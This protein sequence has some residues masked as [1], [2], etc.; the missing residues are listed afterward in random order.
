MVT[1]IGMWTPLGGRDDT[2]R[3]LLAGRS[4][5]REVAAR[6]PWCQR[7]GVAGLAELPAGKS[8]AFPSKAHG[9]AYLAASEAL[10]DAGLAGPAWPSSRRRKDDLLVNLQRRSL[11]HRS[12]RRFLRFG[13]RTITS[14][15]AESPRPPTSEK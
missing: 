3:G 13:R 12:G 6:A 10:E 14:W 5:V 1:G 7:V 15:R 11:R 8:A 2:W 4:G 9:A